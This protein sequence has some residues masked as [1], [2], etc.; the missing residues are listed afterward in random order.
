MPRESSIEDLNQS[1]TL[2]FTSSAL[3]NLASPHDFSHSLGDVEIAVKFGTT[4]EICHNER[5]SRWSIPNPT[6][7]WLG[8]GIYNDVR[9]ILMRKGDIDAKFNFVTLSKFRYTSCIYHLRLQPS[10][11]NQIS[12]V[13]LSRVSC[14]YYI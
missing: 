12:Q 2:V 3:H 6:N 14:G 9:K 1:W 4:F 10:T 11:A 13:C 7:S 8:G 5:R